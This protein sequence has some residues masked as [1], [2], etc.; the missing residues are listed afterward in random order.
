[1]TFEE[2]IAQIKRYNVPMATAIVQTRERYKSLYQLDVKKFEDTIYKALYM[3]IR[4]GDFRLPT[5]I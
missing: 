2:K 1:M 5:K 4:E 3:G